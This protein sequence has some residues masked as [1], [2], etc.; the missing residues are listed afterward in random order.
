MLALVMILQLSAGLRT[1]LKLKKIKIIVSLLQ[2]RKTNFSLHFLLLDL[3][4]NFV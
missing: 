2:V 4:I 1:Q 3:L